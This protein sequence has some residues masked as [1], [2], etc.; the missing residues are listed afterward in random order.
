MDFS[1]LNSRAEEVVRTVREFGGEEEVEVMYYSKRAEEARMMEGTLRNVDLGSRRM[2]INID[3]EDG[4]ALVI[5]EDGHLYSVG[6][7]YPDNG[8]VAE[9]KRK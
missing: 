8:P 7:H 1:W 6:S 2:R 9:V 3:R 5:K 4:Q